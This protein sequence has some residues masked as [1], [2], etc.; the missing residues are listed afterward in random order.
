MMQVPAWYGA[1]LYSY[2]ILVLEHIHLFLISARTDTGQ[3]VGASGTCIFCTRTVHF[4]RRAVRGR[5]CRSLII[6]CI[7]YYYLLCIYTH[8]LYFE[9]QYH[10]CS[11]PI[12]TNVYSPRLAV[13]IKANPVLVLVVFSLF[14]VRLRVLSSQCSCYINFRLQGYLLISQMILHSRGYSPVC[15][16][17]VCLAFAGV[18]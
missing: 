18:V 9:V 7:T 10:S 17:F 11:L 12:S 6:G 13:R 8:I 2:S 5:V 3:I 4:A 16:F 1:A 14:V 15:F